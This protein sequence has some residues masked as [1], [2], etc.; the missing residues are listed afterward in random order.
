MKLIIHDLSNKDFISISKNTNFTP[1]KNCGKIKDNYNA[2]N[3]GKNEKIL[4]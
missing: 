4:S 2:F 3:G 1:N